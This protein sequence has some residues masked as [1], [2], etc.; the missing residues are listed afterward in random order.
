MIYKFF[1]KLQKIR[2]FFS[3]S[4]KLIVKFCW[5]F[6]IM[7]IEYFKTLK[8]SNHF[9]FNILSHKKPHVQNIL[10]L[11]ILSLY[12]EILKSCFKKICL[13]ICKCLK[14]CISLIAVYA[15]IFLLTYLHFSNF[16]SVCLP[17]RRII[18]DFAITLYYRHK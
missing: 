17:K 2:F 11:N 9:P 12:C 3:I 14:K 10:I 4:I 16:R 6:I 18:S 1:N 7:C 5:K 8:V 13:K 15:I